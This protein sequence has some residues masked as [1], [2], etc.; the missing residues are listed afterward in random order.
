M[1]WSRY[2]NFSEPEFRC[3][4][5][6]QCHMDEEFVRRLQLVRNDYGKPMRVTSGYRHPTHPVEAAKRSR[7]AGEHTL[8]RAADIACDNG[9]DRFQLVVYAM[10]HGLTRIGIARGFVHLGLG[11]PG[12]PNPVLWEYT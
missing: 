8:G 2:P 10:R 7:T 3:R 1:D 6:G 9:S 5:T 4:H 11:G 12:L